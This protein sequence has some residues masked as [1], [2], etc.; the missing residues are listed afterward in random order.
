MDGKDKNPVGKPR[1]TVEDRLPN[2]WRS[3]IIEEM[4]EGASLIEIKAYFGISNNLHTRW[5]KDETEYRETIKEGVY[6]SEAWWIKQGRK[7]LKDRDFSAVLW[8][9]NMKNRFGWKDRQDVTTNDKELPQPIL[10]GLSVKKS[11]DDGSTT[12]Q[13]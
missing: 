6:K 3:Y 7:N 2:N 12:Q 11:D 1:E 5:M 8:Y 13:Q 9:M 10:G 4:S